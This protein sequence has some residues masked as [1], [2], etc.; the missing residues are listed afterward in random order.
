M[1]QLHLF[2]FCRM[3]PGVGS[4]GEA[5]TKGTLLKTAAETHL[6]LMSTK[7]QQKKI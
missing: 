5:V 6:L 4:T 1:A 7:K 2:L 3:K